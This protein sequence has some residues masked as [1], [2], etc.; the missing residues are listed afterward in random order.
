MSA[1]AKA[2]LTA[3]Y[4]VRDDDK[5]L[6]LRQVAS[7]ALELLRLGLPEDASVHG[8]TMLRIYDGL[9]VDPVTA[10]RA[11]A[12]VSQPDEPPA[13]GPAG[14]EVAG[15]AGSPLPPAAPATDAPRPFA[16]TI[17]ELSELAAE[18]EREVLAEEKAEEL[19]VVM[20]QHIRLAALD[21]GLSARAMAEA[22]VRMGW[23]L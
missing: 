5:P 12:C 18:R 10:R 6:T 17:A 11:I 19:I 2:R 16:S 1:A 7:G 3:M 13:A 9:P 8:V 23:H 15:A 14:D 20:R 4:E 21:G 22:L